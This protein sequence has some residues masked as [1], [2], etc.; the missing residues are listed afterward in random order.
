MGQSHVPEVERAMSRSTLF[1]N[2]SG[3]RETT[4]LIRL[5]LSGEQP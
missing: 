5:A 1:V 2:D 4:A 3:F